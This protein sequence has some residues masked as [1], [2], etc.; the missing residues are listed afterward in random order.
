MAIASANMSHL[1]LQLRFAKAFMSHIALMNSGISMLASFFKRTVFGFDSG[2]DDGMSLDGAADQQLSTFG[3]TTAKGH[4]HEES[5]RRGSRGIVEETPPNPDDAASDSGESQKSVAPS[6][7]TTSNRMTQTLRFKVVE[8]NI[9]ETESVEYLSNL[10]NWEAQPFVGQRRLS[11]SVQFGPYNFEELIDAVKSAADASGFST[12]A[13]RGARKSGTSCSIKF[14]CDHGRVRYGKE[15]ST[16][17]A[18]N[19][20][21]VKDLQ[22]V[23]HDQPG[24]RRR[25][26]R[27]G[28]YKK[29]TTRRQRVKNKE[30]NFNLCL[31]SC[32]DNWAPETQCYWTLNGD[33]RCNCCFQHR[34]HCKRPF[35]SRMSDEIKSYIIE[36]GERMLI[37]ELVAHIFRKFRVEVSCDQVKYVLR[38]NTIRNLS[39]SGRQHFRPG[40]TVD[41][42]RYLLAT[43][44]SDV[45]LL[46]I[47]CETGCWYNGVPDKLCEAVSLEP[48]ELPRMQLSVTDPTREI[49]IKGSKYIAWAAAWNYHAERDLF[50]A[51]D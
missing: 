42:I 34:N 40:G 12:Y 37:S 51:E 36:N 26:R 41:S 8:N 21:F 32:G 31:R 17:G 20:D 50:S 11:P 15:K 10:L 13:F 45:L 28:G 9:Q 33:A 7:M 18:K 47:N 44:T 6:T 46:L 1:Q 22:D 19:R 48:Y 3:S 43:E 4:T 24:K 23:V 39:S 49:V 27:C 29:S 14:G 30:C 25:P 5:Q 38:K 35:R 16:I 2:D